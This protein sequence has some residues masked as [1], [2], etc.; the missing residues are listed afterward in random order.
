MTG[1][2]ERPQ[3]RVTEICA[4][5][6]EIDR[7]MPRM[8]AA[9]ISDEARSVALATEYRELVCELEAL[10]KQNRSKPDE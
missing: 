10:A 7:Q 1:T 5:L 3:T 9:L 8:A 2:T 6:S 4:R